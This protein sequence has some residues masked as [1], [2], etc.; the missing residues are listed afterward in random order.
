LSIVILDPEQCSLCPVS[1]CWHKCGVASH[2]T[3]CQIYTSSSSTV[4]ILQ[5]I[6]RNHVTDTSAPSAS[7]KLDLATLIHLRPAEIKTYHRTAYD[8]PSPSNTYDGKNKTV[9]VTGGGSWMRFELISAGA[10]SS[11]KQVASALPLPSR[12]PKLGFNIL[13]FSRDDRRSL[14]KRR[15][16][17]KPSIQIPKSPRT[18]LLSPISNASLQFSGILVR[19]TSWFRTSLPPTLLSRAKT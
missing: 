6:Q 5:Y 10:D 14:A 17:C 11:I 18:P 16:L 15:K 12:S 4:K 19:S 7:N 3:I 13:F 9:L 8:R 1:S 2:P